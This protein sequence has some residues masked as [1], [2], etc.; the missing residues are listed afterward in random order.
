MERKK[1]GSIEVIEAKTPLWFNNEPIF[2]I[3]HSQKG[4]QKE[5][6]DLYVQNDI[7]FVDLPR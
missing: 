3:S 4:N 1:S 7:H 6:P 5:N 2:D